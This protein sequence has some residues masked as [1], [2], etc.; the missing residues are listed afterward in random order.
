MSEPLI[1][2]CYGCVAVVNRAHHIY[3]ECQFQTI[4]K[5]NNNEKMTKNYIY[6]T[7][8]AQERGREAEREEQEQQSNETTWRQQVIASDVCCV[9]L[10]TSSSWKLRSF[11]FVEIK[12][13]I[14]FSFTVYRHFHLFIIFC[15]LYSVCMWEFFV[16]NFL[17]FYNNIT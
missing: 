15:L 14:C 2:Y 4:W 11:F 17:Q 13:T 12:K 16:R 1:C 9:V 8:E 3:M 7:K 6:I 10:C 5:P